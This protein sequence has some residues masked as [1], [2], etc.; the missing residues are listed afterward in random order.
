MHFS[1]GLCRSVD[2]TPAEFNHLC[3]SDSFA[4]DFGV[5]MQL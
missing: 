1:V 3:G 2:V 5:L 4:A